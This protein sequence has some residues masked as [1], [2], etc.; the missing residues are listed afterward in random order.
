MTLTSTVTYISVGSVT[1]YAPRSGMILFT[2]TAEVFCSALGSVGNAAARISVNVDS[3]NPW[4]GFDYP[5]GIAD[6]MATTGPTFFERVITITAPFNVSAG[7][8]TVHMVARNDGGTQNPV[9]GDR[10]MTAIFVD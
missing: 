3:T 7:S 5:I 2:A 1:I 8:H 9:M 4:P 6:C 10:L